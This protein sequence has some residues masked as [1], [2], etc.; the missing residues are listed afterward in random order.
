MADQRQQFEGR[1]RDEV[2]RDVGRNADGDRQRANTDEP[3]MSRPVI[4]PFRQHTLFLQRGD[5]LTQVFLGFSFCR[6]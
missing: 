5:L 1:M 2:R 3:A 4:H 6:P